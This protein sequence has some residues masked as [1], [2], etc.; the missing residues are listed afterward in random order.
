VLKGRGLADKAHQRADM[1]D[2]ETG[3]QGWSEKQTE[4]EWESRE[5]VH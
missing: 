2:K 4:Q 3:K 1:A 5:G